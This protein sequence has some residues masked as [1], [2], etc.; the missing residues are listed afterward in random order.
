MTAPP[1]ETL[2]AALATVND[3]EI[4]KPVTELGM[5]KAVAADESGHVVLDLYLTVAGLPAEGHP[6]QRHNS[7]AHEGPGVTGVTGAPRRHERRAARRP[8]DQAARWGRR[9]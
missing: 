7:R 9:A 6:A 3:P 4:R 5:V 8:E 1:T 2:L